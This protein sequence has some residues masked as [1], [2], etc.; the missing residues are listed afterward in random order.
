MRNAPRTALVVALLAGLGPA[1]LCA[2]A[3]TPEPT[4]APASAEPAKPAEVK[5][6]APKGPTAFQ[7]KVGDNANIRFGIMLQPQADW[8]QEP[9]SGGYQQN[10][11][12]RRAR[13]IVSGQVA[14]DVFFFLQ[15]ENSSLG[16]VSAAGTKV[17]SSGFQILDAVAEWRIAK[18]FNVWAGLIYVPTSREALKSSSTEFMLDASAYAYTATGAL[19][20]T[21]GR[22]TG[23]LAR[24]YLLE[25]RL[26]YR[27]GVFQGLRDSASRNPFRSVSRLQYNFLD[28]E[29]Y[30]LPAYPGSNFGS[31]KILALGAACD[32]QKDYKGFAADLFADIP[33]SFGSVVGIALGQWWDGGVTLPTLPKQNTFSVDLGAYFKG[34]KLGPWV[35]YE[36]RTYSD[37]ANASKDEK[38]Y[39]VG[40]NYYVLGNNLNLKA[41]YGRV[42]PKVGN[43]TNQFTIQLQAYYF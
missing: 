21:G 1:P 27:V 36:Q 17:I 24:G 2:Q 42:D 13:L 39:L 15:T 20:G 14:K 23:F 28:K 37:S 41:G 26:E 38:R 7:I 29:V 4:K 18:E 35:R 25:D 19:A 30:N 16:K 6:E 22:D 33:T 34:S 9:V 11:F 3:P 12:L 10:L 8:T 40:L 31:K 43:S 32:F 5:K